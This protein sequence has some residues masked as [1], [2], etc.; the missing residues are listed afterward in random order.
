[1][2]YRRNT[3][4]RERRMQSLERDVFIHK[5]NSREL[6]QTIKNMT[7]EMASMSSNN[8]MTS[9]SMQGHPVITRSDKET[10]EPEFGLAGKRI[11]KKPDDKLT[12][13][14]HENAELKG[15]LNNL[16]TY[17]QTAKGITSVKCNVKNLT[18]ME[19]RPTTPKS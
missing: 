9:P 15:E 10:R 18:K 12:V 4:Q 16:L 3:E 8:R 19:T 13:L 6:E 1:M 7:S 2:K 11:A 17:L 5:Q 14:E